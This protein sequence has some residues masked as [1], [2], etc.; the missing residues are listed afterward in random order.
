V[1]FFWSN[2]VGLILGVLLGIISLVIAFFVILAALTVVGGPDPCTPDGGPISI[3]QANSDAFQNKWD[4][5]D[6]TLDG[7]SS[8]SENF[9]ESEVSSRADR[10]LTDESDAPFTDVRVCLHEGY[11]EGTAK[12]S[13]IGIDVKVKVKGNMELTGPSPVAKID[14]IEVGSVPGFVT[15]VIEGIVED[16]IEEGLEDIELKHDYQATLTEGNAQIDGTP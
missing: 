13:I 16:A 1:S 4:A 2:P 12:L 14:D 5:M 3:T 8:A 15:G 10:Y 11:G 9:N 6:E 7:G